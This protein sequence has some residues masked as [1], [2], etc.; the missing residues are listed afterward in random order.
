MRDSFWYLKNCDLFT[1]L[2]PPDIAELETQSRMKTL[3]RGEPV[4]LPNQAADGVI[5]IA[6]GR[7]KICHATPDG[8]QS[9]LNLIDPGEIFGELA[10]VTDERRNEYAEAA[11]A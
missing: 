5:L 3:K 8:K 11:E 1:R 7:V 6:Q 2:S 10:I 9:I 4:Y